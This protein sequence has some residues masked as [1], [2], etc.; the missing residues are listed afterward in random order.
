MSNIYETVTVK[1]VLMF[2]LLFPLHLHFVLIVKSNITTI[3]FN[4]M[5]KTIFALNY[6]WPCSG[7]TRIV[8]WHKMVHILLL[9]ELSY[10]MSQIIC[11]HCMFGVERDVTTVNITVKLL[12]SNY[13]LTVLLVCGCVD[14]VSN[15]S[16]I[17]NTWS[18]PQWQNTFGPNMAAVG[19]HMAVRGLT[20]AV[21]GLRT[22]A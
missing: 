14:I 10:L 19:L 12:L 4:T 8:E 22:C 17:F 7:C 6:F 11:F 20:V 1:F 13:E 16:W 9:Y 5:T 18:L 2:Y 3:K 15:I 21:V